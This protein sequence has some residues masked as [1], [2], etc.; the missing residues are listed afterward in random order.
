MLWTYMLKDG[1]EVVACGDDARFFLNGACAS[2][3]PP[4]PDAECADCR[5]ARLT[6]PPDRPLDPTR[7]NPMD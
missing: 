4:N 3:R 5:G 6:R 2:P 1:S 7:P